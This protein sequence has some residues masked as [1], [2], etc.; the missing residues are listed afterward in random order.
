MGP[1]GLTWQGSWKQSATYA[2]SDAVSYA[3]S[4]YISLL[5]TNTGNEPGVA[6]AGWSLLAS[7]GET[8]PQGPGG[9]VGPT[10]QTGLTGA[11]GPTGPA[12]NAGAQGPVG[13][14]FRGSWIFGFPYRINDAVVYKG[15]TYISLYP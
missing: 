12:G 9:A 2:L 5:A 1:Q 10:G 8:G 13:M 11:T 14:V 6:P 3:G 7:V 15:S 4:G